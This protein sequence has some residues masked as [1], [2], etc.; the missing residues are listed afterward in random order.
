MRLVLFTAALTLWSCVISD[1]VAAQSPWDKSLPQV[2]DDISR[3]LKCKWE[4]K[5]CTP[6]G[7]EGRLYLH[8]DSNG[9]RVETV[10]F[11]PLVDPR[12][13]RPEAE[14]LNSNIAFKV[15]AY[16]LPAWKERE[17]W[18]QGALW[19]AAHYH[20][21]ETTK[22]GRINI[23]VENWQFADLDDVYA[24]IV[25]TRKASLKG[26]MANWD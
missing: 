5:S 18:V 26:F 21:R 25:L 1:V 20:E 9:K 7:F 16:F 8:P 22:V 2:Q 24:K 23:L 6:D 4:K 15:F 3:L 19:T 17:H 12:P 13:P 14:A 11:N 10:E